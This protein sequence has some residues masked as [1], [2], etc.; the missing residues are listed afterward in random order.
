MNSRQ[1]NIKIEIKEIVSKNLN[2]KRNKIL[3]ESFQL[4]SYDDYHAVLKEYM[5]TSAKL[6]NEGYELNEITDYIDQAS[7]S[8]QNATGKNWDFGGMFKDS[9][10][11]MGKEVALKWFF[12]YL[13]FKPGTSKIL[14]QGL[15]DLS[16]KTILIPFKNREYCE[17]NLP[18][19]L[20]SIFEVI[21]RHYIDKNIL[22]TPKN[23][24]RD[25]LQLDLEKQ[26]KELGKKFTPKLSYNTWKWSDL[27]TVLPVGNVVGEVIRKSDTSET[28]ADYF[29]KIIHK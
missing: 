29:C 18:N 6:M 16:P 5:I 14:A 26:A 23:R 15:A 13:G 10:W 24:E 9:L 3:Q 25:R 28:L 11:S 19:L 22:I 2:Q 27:V 21:V 20:D 4:D 1:N 7:Q 12:E 17:K 8:L